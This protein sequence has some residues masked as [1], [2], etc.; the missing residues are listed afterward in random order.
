ME[1]LHENESGFFHGRGHGARLRLIRRGR[2]LAKHM[3]ARLQR[4]DA[5]PRVQAVGQRDIHAIDIRVVEQRIVTGVPARDTVFARI[6]P[7]PLPV[8]RRHRRNPHPAR[9]PHRRQKS[10]SINSSNRH[11]PKVQHGRDSVSSSN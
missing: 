11:N 9:A 5:P 8:A 3:L 2:L 7:C 4:A 6:A 1:P 10:I